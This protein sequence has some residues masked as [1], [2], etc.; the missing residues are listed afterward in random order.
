[1]KPF[2][3]LQVRHWF[4]TRVASQLQ[5]PK[6]FLTGNHAARLITGPIVEL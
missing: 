3:N 2:P 6:R 1:M 5:N 4:A